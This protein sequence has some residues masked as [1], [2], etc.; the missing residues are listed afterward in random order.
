LA[1]APTTG[2]VLIG[3]TVD[4]G[5]KLQ[6]AGSAILSTAEPVLNLS[7]TA[8]SSIAYQLIAGGGSGHTTGTFKIYDS[9]LGYTVLSHAKGTSGPSTR[10]SFDAAGVATFA[11]TAASTSTTT[12]A[13]VVSGGVG[14]AGA[15][16]FGGNL[17]V[18]GQGDF[19]TGI[20][21]TGSPSLPAAWNGARGLGIDGSSATKRIYFGDGTGYFLKFSSRIASTTT[22]RFTF[23]D[24]G[25][26]TATGNLTV[27]GTG[28]SSVAGDFGVGTATPA[29]RLQVISGSSP[30]AAQVIV[31]YG[32]SN[33][34]FDA[35]DNIFRNGSFTES[36]RL[37]STGNL[38][39]GTTTDSGNGKLQLATHTTSAGGIGFGTD[40]SLYRLDQYSIALNGT[41]GSSVL[42]FYE[43]GTLKG[44]IGTTA[45]TTYLDS[46]SGSIILRT[47]GGT[48]ALTLDSSQRCILAGA[49]RLNNA[50]V[51][52]APTA[53]GYVTL[54][55]SAGNTYKVLVGT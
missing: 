15:G 35:N 29:G 51:S 26:F 31:G 14:V 37:K 42:R 5:Q 3:S 1:I 36:M 38:L 45:G 23:D 13:L 25:N 46:L 39:L 52:G 17:T 22:D 41:A 54:Q 10:L 33:N 21:T 2:N 24:T 48:T 43:S 12:G 16:Y 4:G 50:Y 20:T 30:N 34:F 6:V 9:S 44:L 11:S 47:N 55:D 49:L 19:A 28:V 32:G 7:S 40:W 18:S 8:A 27:G 53:T